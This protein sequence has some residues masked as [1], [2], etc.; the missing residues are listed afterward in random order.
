MSGR[1][2]FFRKQMFAESIDTCKGL[3]Y[4][5]GVNRGGRPQGRLTRRGSLKTK[6]WGQSKNELCGR[7]RF[8]EPILLQLAFER[9]GGDRLSLE[10]LILAQDERLRRA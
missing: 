7:E 9:G 6:Q 3:W 10:S 8:R 5:M 1:R 2:E 4:T